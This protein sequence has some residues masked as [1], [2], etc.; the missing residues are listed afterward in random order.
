MDTAQEKNIQKLEQLISLVNE[1]LT[2]EEF[3]KSFENIISIVLKIEKRNSDAVDNLETTYATLLK[4][5]TDSSASSVEEVKSR[6]Q[7]FMDDAKQLLEKA[8]AEL[9]TKLSTVKD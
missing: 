8:R 7:Y 4:Q 1:G 3:V 5:V 2:R 9:L 6:A